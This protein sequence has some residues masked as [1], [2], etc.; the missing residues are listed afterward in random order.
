VLVRM[1]VFGKG[2]VGKAVCAQKYCSPRNRPGRQWGAVDCDPHW[3]K[4]YKNTKQGGL[5]RGG[6]FH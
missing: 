6:S 4:K 3:E 2:C 5:Y 1:G